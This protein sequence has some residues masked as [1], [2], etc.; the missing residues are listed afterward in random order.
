MYIL[1]KR[2]C[3]FLNRMGVK[4]YKIRAILLIKMFDELLLFYIYVNVKEN[5]NNYKLIGE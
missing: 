2:L 1:T 3:A 4:R 5:K